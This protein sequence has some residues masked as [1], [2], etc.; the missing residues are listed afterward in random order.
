VFYS[1]RFDLA[2]FA[3]GGFTAALAAAE[4]EQGGNDEPDTIYPMFMG[5][6]IMGG[7]SQRRYGVRKARGYFTAL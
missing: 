5:A 6:A 7:A 2:L 3:F 1:F 4:G